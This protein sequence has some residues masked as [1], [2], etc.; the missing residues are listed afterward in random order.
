MPGSVVGEFM[1]FFSVL[2]RFSAI[3][4]PLIYSYV[5][6][7]TGNPR[8]SLPVITSFFVIGFLILRK[9]DM[10]KTITEEEWAAI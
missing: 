4:G 3:W 1:G 10:D 6:A 9:V 8:L 2:S 5:S 7:T